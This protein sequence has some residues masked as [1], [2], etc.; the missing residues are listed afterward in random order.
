MK[1]W[2]DVS[3]TIHSSRDPWRDGMLFFKSQTGAQS[4]ALIDGE[5]LF[6]LTSC[7]VQFWAKDLVTYWKKEK[8]KHI[9]DKS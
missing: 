9:W 3:P 5:D 4:L 6:P 1:C 7:A 2:E 8:K